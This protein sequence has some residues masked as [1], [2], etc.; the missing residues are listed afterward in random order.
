MLPWRERDDS[1]V[2]ADIPVREWALSWWV[3][4]GQKHKANAP[5]LIRLAD[6]HTKLGLKAD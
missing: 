5:P 3:M 1:C 4:H 6:H 2:M